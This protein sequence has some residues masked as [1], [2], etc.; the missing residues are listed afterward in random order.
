[1]N[2]TPHYTKNTKFAQ[3]R[4]LA[5]LLATVLAP[6]PS[7]F[8]ANGTWTN[9]VG[10]SWATA[11]NWTN[12]VIAA[13]SGNTA[14]FSE[15][16]L[17]TAPTVTLDGAQTIGNMIF[18]DQ[19]NTYGWTLNTGTGGPLT[20]AGGTPTITVNNQTTTVGVGLAGSAGLVKAGSGTLVLSGPN[21]YTGNTIVTNGTLKL[22]TPVVNASTV[23][24]PVL[25]MSFDNVVTG[26]ATNVIND[27]S[28]GSVMN[29][30]LVG[31]ASIVSGG[32]LG[33]NCLS[34]PATLNAG[35]VAITNSVV[36]FSGSTTWT[37]AMWIK[38]TTAGG[39]YLYQ[40]NGGWNNTGGA[41]TIFHLNN[42]GNNGAGSGMGLDTRGGTAGGV[43]Y[44]RGWESGST[45]INDGNWHFVV[46]TCNANNTH[47]SYVDGNVDA[48]SE[49]TWSGAAGGTNVWIGACGET[50]DGVAGLNGLIDE[51]SIYNTTL[52]QA[53]VQ[54]LMA[55]GTVPAASPVSV[56]ASSTLNL[57]GCSQIVAGLSGTGTVDSTLAAG[58]PM[59][60]VNTTTASTFGGVI[61][62]TAGN[63]SL[64]KM[65][66]STLTLN[67]TAANTY[68]GATIV[69]GGTLIEDFANAT[70]PNNLIN[71]SS[72]LVLGGGTFQV[73]QKSA[74][75]TSQTFAG[76]TV[77]PGT[78]AVIGTQVTSGALSLALGAI[79]QN[80]GGA[81]DF[82]TPTGGSITTTSPN[83]NGILGGWATTGNTVSSTT[84]GDW[85]ATNG[86]GQIVTYTGYTPIS[87][88]AS[89]TPSLTGSSTQNWL[90][91]ALNG[92]NNVT[93]LSAS[94]TINSLVGQGDIN[95]PSGD[96]LTVNSGGIILRGVA[97]WILNNNAGNSTGTAKIASG[98]ATGDL[99]VHTPNTAASWTI[100]PNIVDGS[101]PTTLIKDG[102]GLVYL[103]NNNTYTAG[104]LVN[105]GTLSVNKGGGTGGIRGVATVNPGATLQF[106][107]VD[108]GGY[109][110]NLCVNA[111][112]INGGT[113][114]NTSGGN[115]G[116][117]YDLN[118]TGGTVTSTGG[119][120]VFSAQ[121]TPVY[122]INTLASSQGSLISAPIHFN[123]LGFFN[124]AQ[125]TV[126]NGIDL[127]VSG[128]INN[129]TGIFKNGAGTILLSGVNT[130]AGGWTNN[131]GTVIV[132][133]N[134]AFGTG[135]VAFS[136]GSI[137]NNAGTSYTLVN[138]INLASTISAGVGS[139]DTLT[140]SGLITGTGG[141]TKVGAGTLKFNIANS[142]SGN[143]TVSGGTLALG[144]SSG[145]SSSP[146]ITVASGAILDVS[147]ISG[148]TLGGSQI[149]Y[150]GGTN[151]GSLNTS[152][153]TKIYAGT[154]GGYGTNTVV[155]N[156]TLASGAVC[157]FDL[158]TVYN[159]AN[160]EIVVTGNLTNNANYIHIKAPSTAVGMDQSADYVLF[161]A[162]NI[163]GTFP[164]APV[165]DVTPTNSTHFRIVTTSTNVTLHYDAG[166][167]MPS[168][169]G[170][171]VTVTRNQTT[172]ISVTVI[173]GTY[174]VNTV[175]V[176]AS[177]LGGSSALSL[178][179][180]NN[181]VY[182]NAIIIPPTATV[183]VATLPVTIT[184]VNTFF[185][186]TNIPVTVVVANQ[187]WN[188]GS[189]TDNNWTS[190]PNWTSGAGPAYAGDSVT[191]DGSTRLTPSVN[192]NYS[193][194]GL[195]FNSTAGSFTIGTAN[196][197]ALTLTAGGVVNNSANA[198]I[199]NVPV[200]LSA[201]QTLNAAAGPLTLGQNLTNGGY[202]VTVSGISNTV[203]SGAI[204]GAG[205]LAITGTGNLSLAGTNTYSGATTVS[206]GSL[207]VAPTGLLGTN[208][209]TV[210]TSTLNVVG[211]STNNGLDTIGGTAGVAVLNIAGGNLQANDHSGQLYNSGL[212]LSTVAGAA[213]DIQ[214][215][216]GTLGVYDQLGI[217]QSAFGGYSQSGGTTT[218]GG[219]IALGGTA[220]G[221]VFNQSG[222]TVNMTGSSAT[223]GYSVT[224]SIGV[225]NLSGTAVFNANPNGGAFGGGIWPG[226]VGTGI[227]NVSGSASLVI[228]HD[229]LV[230]GKGNVA[231]NGTVN[232]LGG[233]VTANS[234]YKGTGTGT[235]NFNGGTLKANM[236]TNAFVSGLTA[237]YIY[238]NG[239]V[240][241]SGG[242]NITIP[243]T[244]LPPTGYGVQ[245]ITVATGG[246]GYIETPIVIITNISAS[247][248]GATAVANISGGVVTS[249]TVTCPGQGYGSSDILGVSII[250]G[251]GSGA[252]A[253][254]PG[255]IP[256]AGGGL[257][258]VG[259]G[260]L[261][262]G[263]GNTYSSDNLT[264]TNTTAVLGGTL[265]WNYATLSYP[266]HLVVSNGTFALDASSGASYS[267]VNVTLQTNA[268]VTIAYGSASPGSFT[269]I[270]AGG[271]LV[272]SGTN[273]INIS[274]SGFTTLGQQVS[275]MS[276]NGTPLGSISNFK[277]G[278]LPVGVSGYLSNNA[279]AT[280]P[281][282]D[283]VVT[284]IGQ[285]LT[286]SGADSGNNV[287]T[288]WNINTTEDWNNGG[289]NGSAFYLEYGA[290]P[291][292]FG[293]LVT[294]DD[295]LYN[296]Q[297]T[298]V[299]LT[300][301]LHPSSLTVISS[302]PYSFTG[303]GSIA[304]AVSLSMS[305]PGS[306]FLGTSNSYS[307]GTIINNGTVV[308]TNDS[309]LGASSGLVTMGGGILEFA[310]NTTSTR[311]VTFNANTTLDV[312]TNNTAI[313][314]AAISGGYALTKTDNGALSLLGNS[315]FSTVTLNQ[316][317][318][319]LLGNNA[320]GGTLTQNAGTLATA[321]SNQIT[322]SLI[323]N[324]GIYNNS[325]TNVIVGV[326][327][328][329][330]A[331]GYNAVINNSGNLTQSNLF[332]GQ[333][334]GAYGAVYQ[335]GGTVT[336]TGGGG[337]C[338]DVGNIQGAF[339]YYDMIGGTVTANGIAVGGENNTGTGF[340]ATSTGGNGIMD[341]NGGNVNNVGWFV[342]GRAQNNAGEAGILNV[343]S[344]LMTYA[345]GGIQ[346]NWGTNQTSI[347][348]MMGGVVTN[349]LTTVGVSMN[350]SGDASNVGVLNLDGGLIQGNAVTGGNSW[351]N[352]N[353]GTL[354]ASVAS[355]TFVTGLGRATVYNGGATIDDNGN[356]IT[357]GQ[358]LLAATGYGVSSIGLST[359]GSGYI[360][361]PT[362]TITGGSGSNA[363]ATAM[364]SGGAVTGII[365]T[366]PGTGYN[367]SD[368]LTVG[369]SGGGASASGAT[370]GT[371]SF[372]LNGTGGLTK[373][374]SGTLT[375][376]GV[377][378]FAGPITNNAGTLTL[379]SASS[380]AGSAVVNGG[381]LQLTTASQIAGNVSVN[382]GATLA[383]TQIG[384]ATN[385]LGNLTLG[386][387]AGVGAT[388]SLAL[389]NG[390]TTPPL[391]NC[392][393]LSLTGSNTISISGSFTV[394]AVP[395]VHYSTIT[396]LSLSS[397]A[398]NIIAPRG[399][400]ATWSNSVSS[401]TLYAVIVSTGA[402]IVWTGTSPVHPSLWDVNN[403]T[404]W[405][406]LGTPTTY[407]QSVVP[408]DA[409]LF[410]DS[411]L[412]LV[413]L[414]TN[415]SPAN[416]IISNSATSYAFSGSG[417]LSGTT[418]LTKIGTGSA[419]ISYA[420][421]SYTGNTTISNG[422]LQLGVAN[423]IPGGPGYGN[424]SVNGTLDLSTYSD[425]VNNLSGSG[426]VDTV[427]GG[428]PTLTVSNSAAT[429]FAGA[430]KNTTG[431]LNFAKTGT[432]TLTL[433][434]SNTFSGNLFVNSGTI[435]ITNGGSANNIATWVS[436][437][438]VG[439]DNGTMM[440]KGNGSLA[441]TL[442]FNVGD[443]GSAVGTLDVQDSAS[444]TVSN[445]YVASA[446]ASGSTASGTVNQYGGTVT[447]TSANVGTF[448]I[449]GRTSASG[450]GVYN[451][452]GGTLTATAGIR[453][454]SYGTGTF[455]QNGGTVNAKGGVNIARL[456]GSTGFYYLNAGTLAA[457]NLTSSTAVNANFYFNG[458][459]LQAA[460]TPAYL[461][462]T[463]LTTATVMANGALIDSQTNNIVIS[464]ALLD[465]GTGGG[466]TKFGSGTLY[467][468]GGNTYTG[469]TMVTNGT[470]AGGGTISGPVVVAPAGNLGAG[471]VGATVGTLTINNNL[472]LQGNASL[473]INRDASPNCDAI[474]GVGNITYGGTLTITNLSST[475][476]TTSDTFQLFSPS[477]SI[478]GNFTNIVGSPGAGLAYSFNTNSGVLSVVSSGPGTFTS[479]P[480]ITSFTLS[481][482]NVVLTGT[483]G[484]SGD[485]YYLLSSTNV[486]LPL[487]Q[488]QTV[489]TNVL[490]GAGSFT[491]TGTN[492]VSVGV[493]QQFYILSNTNSNH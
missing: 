475:P 178:V 272:S 120:F 63:L 212:V 417:H 239:A 247:G 72:T 465:G 363:L 180:S 463:N 447:Q 427:A 262:L 197:S 153:G 349:T 177:L 34:I 450:V 423:A 62:N 2:T 132:G 106:N 329:G 129:S 359:G 164:V 208:T 366:C 407:Q 235:L 47:V 246:A 295:S 317:T 255:L 433:T 374:G 139:G 90:C 6:M 316:G 434:G 375:L 216:S 488:W 393:T 179:L 365:V 456:A 444:L 218:I 358:P 130:F 392:S 37:V 293:D 439:T 386:Q 221:G 269:P 96:T 160:D 52:S 100:W 296:Q 237:A 148:F 445:L 187:V 191:F 73:K 3:S 244:L 289:G 195:T 78:T 438:Q 252:S 361:P 93:T 279:T 319:S 211:T 127:T 97:R 16:S 11:A 162:A 489:A 35:Y 156:L 64:A 42:G 376:T 490:S 141:L 70:S 258:K 455:N 213:G 188:G 320:I 219:F 173:P 193:L 234:V 431:A 331:G 428:A 205:G 373:N 471:D 89:S 214:M 170:N 30:T 468:D 310:G 314:G 280:P 390:N 440:L 119:N 87:A 17:G 154:D 476:L 112:N 348:N 199:L 174:T 415:I 253:N 362:V 311:P 327:S 337:D 389:G 165:W 411:G 334:S 305:G 135:P 158:G 183:G 426:T 381:S 110:V 413:T 260:T 274:G 466:L 462:M 111:I 400:V 12:S 201:A 418:G 378:T 98:L 370:A 371:I 103:G 372:V 344:G 94:A 229:G 15:L 49:D 20:L 473:R 200:T 43:S 342:M 482:S 263:T 353:G 478:S 479:H 459:L 369:F 380:Y 24:T 294:F 10:G 383:L 336:V 273:I 116:Y 225:M 184:D 181:N 276:Y 387:S 266:G 231:G 452:S 145:I 33:G 151:N 25:Y 486:A 265:N 104:T 457:Y 56:A 230:L 74:T 432:N 169:A 299:I 464:Q 124:V 268:A 412:G 485:A 460:F 232:L 326:S 364:V 493:G 261:S 402:G 416:I 206:S 136:G 394:G 306:L 323:V 421:N 175:V 44:G 142:Y 69:N 367:N 150:G 101:V 60:A 241:D 51:V 54:N 368:T 118:L 396:G 198:Q 182:T 355:T 79:T 291:N 446:N 38:T 29:G 48:W 333:S 172:P 377:N 59:L 76:T 149:L 302:L 143:T 105:G 301:T 194:T 137:S 92:A 83:V 210:N 347:M 487:S 61:A 204:V 391:V 422:V 307:G 192:T 435:I 134:A 290:S 443:I 388:L 287:Q 484:Q 39:V 107:A 28:G 441:T 250:G 408:G 315:T 176:N 264:F 308:V 238:T 102:P 236:A 352:F 385:L 133:N 398:T 82:T 13:G 304:G 403:S 243:Q 399:V 406:I 126:P 469:S 36:L 68:T 26:T 58:T 157:Y 18:G 57:N 401:S 220:G 159:G 341:I 140:L 275:L 117:L 7:V 286:W 270:T 340:V 113:L 322:G 128:I 155:G 277:L 451:I 22:P 281:S 84:T 167:T 477:G 410:N 1:M 81:V 5:L 458:G 75:A 335:T 186:L 65:G 480:G 4:W 332:V 430:I 166:L 288:N 66:A 251:G 163:V 55:A 147:A 144:A 429:T 223:L 14:D 284:L 122:G 203:V 240:I 454:G 257:T 21:T 161:S 436:V 424:T 259:N 242:Y 300:T 71:S 109:T 298:N 224:S 88:S 77:N 474:N 467:L 189:L 95:I 31:S 360:M 313:L 80:V 442:D 339:G 227:L 53:Q 409:V 215:S 282:I 404:N 40:G 384:T 325:G 23:P 248:S 321:G 338:L 292:V 350:R 114:A 448:V 481:G 46:M 382:N 85:A 99:Y 254:T 152:S 202:L 226:E 449:G 343:Y 492:A 346:C 138:S 285:T 297:A 9:S 351:L 45:T 330:I 171:P 249:I 91:G 123:G 453:V 328:F 357:I 414:N 67:G 196:S 190:N 209:V 397:L 345:G 207:T 245:S 356:A 491:F 324:E 217:G 267:P 312:T 146:N 425:L 131:S 108:A 256:N 115:E 27:G 41:N 303:S 19:G 50:G 278:T 233:T 405:S 222:G 420:G 32:R 228:P 470:L 395:L 185:G 437:G 121:S 379:N 271:S 483:N 168:G 472:T 354:R 318:L 125:G 283:F 461:F 86:S 309:G 419:T 8:A